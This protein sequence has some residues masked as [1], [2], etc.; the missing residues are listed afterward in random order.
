MSEAAALRAL[1]VHPAQMLHLDE[2]LGTLEK[3]KD[4]DFV[5]LSGPPFSIYTQVLETY[6]DGVRVYDRSQQKDWLYQAGGFALAEPARRPQPTALVQPLPSSKPTPTAPAAAP[7][8]RGKPDRLVVFASRIHTAANGTIQ[9]GAILVENGVIRFVG[10]R[11]K[12][13]YPENTPV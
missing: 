1:T 13:T 2:R 11:D 5:V 4:A 6:I 12:F 3:G 7:A 9:D 8:A 10:S